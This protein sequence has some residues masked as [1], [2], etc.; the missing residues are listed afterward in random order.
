MSLYSVLQPLGATKFSFFVQGPNL[1]KNNVE[2][3][4]IDVENTITAVLFG[5]LY[6]RPLILGSS[7]CSDLMWTIS[8]FKS[9]GDPGCKRLR[10]NEGTRFKKL[11]ASYRAL[12]GGPIIL[13]IQNS[14]PG[15]FLIRLLRC[16]IHLTIFFGT[17]Y[18]RNLQDPLLGHKGRP[19]SPTRPGTFH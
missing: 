7:T 16:M 15:G 17:T 6:W 1:K 2:S 14:E 9:A 10:A 18:A 4:P 8:S 19:T 11:L 13:D 12:S 5:D 3:C